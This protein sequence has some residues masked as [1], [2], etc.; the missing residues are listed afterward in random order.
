MHK[1]ADRLRYWYQILKQQVWPRF[2]VP[3]AILGHLFAIRDE[4]LPPKLAARLKMPAW[5]PDL[6]WYLWTIALLVIVLA[7]VMEG[8]YRQFRSSQ[9]LQER[10]HKHLMSLIGGYPQDLR[11]SLRDLV[12]TDNPER[13]RG[14][15]WSQ[16]HRDGLV[17]SG[18]DGQ[19]QTRGGIKKELVNIVDAVLRYY[20]Q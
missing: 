6:P 8:A 13:I 11:A 19:W 14:G 17:D 16:F 18:T 3:I 5:L 9:P 12:I 20:E 10:R 7:A 4:F 15:N 2:A 1:I